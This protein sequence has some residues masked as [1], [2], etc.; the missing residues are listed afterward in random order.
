[1]T[2]LL[3]EREIPGGLE[4]AADAGGDDW[5]NTGLWNRIAFSLKEA[6]ER[7]SVLVEGGRLRPLIGAIMCVVFLLNS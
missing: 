1:M 6:N 7:L 3:R 4:A 5:N 2:P